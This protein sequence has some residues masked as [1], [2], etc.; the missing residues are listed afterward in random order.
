MVRDGTVRDDEDLKD[1]NRTVV[2]LGE[3]LGK[4][5]CATGD[6]HFLDPEDEVYRHILLASKKFADANEPVPLYFRTTDEMLKEF[7]YLGKE[8]A[9]EVVVT[10]TRA[11]AEQV[12]DIELLP[13]GK[14]F[15]PRLENSEEDLNRMVWGKAHELYGDDLPQL[16]VDRLNVE[17]GSI[18]GKYDVV[19]MSAQKLVQ[20][21]LEWHHRGQRPAAALPLPEVP[22][23]RVPRGRVWLWRGHA[24]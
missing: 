17:L 10:N 11:I 16:I 3:E 13:K 24:R 21:S 20:R 19:Y 22:Q 23:R 2:K 7:D 15:P 4:P 18:L 12:E 14:L 9:Y 6:V 8:K 5:V 1:F